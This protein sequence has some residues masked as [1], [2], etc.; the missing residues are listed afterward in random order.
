MGCG[1]LLSRLGLSCEM[2]SDEINFI[3]WTGQGKNSTR[4]K[5]FAI[6]GLLCGLYNVLVAGCA[7]AIAKRCE[8][9]FVFRKKI[10]C[11]LLVSSIRHS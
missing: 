11:K 2:D 8:M 6:L 5:R 9:L 3:I 1:L 7:G 4:I 10:G